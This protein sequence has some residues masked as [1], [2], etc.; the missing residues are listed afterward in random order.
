MSRLKE[1]SIA[2][3]AS[4]SG[5]DMKTAGKTVLYSVSVGKTG[6]VL[7][8]VVREPS[9]SMAGGTDYDLGTGANADT[10]RQTI[11]LSSMTTLATDY[12]AIAGADVTKYTDNAAAAAF[13]I[14]VITGTTAA[15]TATIDVFGFEA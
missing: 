13:G 5:V 3:L 2:L 9:A 12:M 7:F 14:K 4:V 10:W 1:L 11:N 15:C 6:Y 8:V